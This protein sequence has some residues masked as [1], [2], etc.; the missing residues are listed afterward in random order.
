MGRRVKLFKKDYPISDLGL[1]LRRQ[2]KKI[3]RYLGHIWRLGILVSV[4]SSTVEKRGVCLLKVSLG[5]LATGLVIICV[6][7]I[8]LP[9]VSGHNQ[10]SSTTFTRPI[11]KI[12]KSP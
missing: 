12:P 4:H 8:N 5:E 10:F 1:P 9:W 7:C 6:D 2:E 3:S 11:T